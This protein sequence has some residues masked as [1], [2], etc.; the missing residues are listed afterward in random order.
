MNRYGSLAVLLCAAA[1]SSCDY[2]K[3]AVQD[4]TGPVPAAQIKFFNFGVDAP[5]VN[6]YANDAK[7]TAVLSSTGTESTAGVI[8][9]GVGAGGLYSGIA[10]GQYTFSGRIAAA[11]DKDLA[12]SNLMATIEDGK[13][14]S[15]YLSGVYNSTT[16]TV[17]AFIV[18]DPF[19]AAIDWST[20]HVR[21]VNA[22]YNA[23]P[24]TLY[25][26]NQT[27][28]VEVAVGGEAAY[29][30]AGA[31][32]ALPNGLYDLSTRYAGSA[33]NAMIRN[34]VSFVAGRDYTITARG[35]ITVAS[36][37]ATTCASTNRTCLDNTLNR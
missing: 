15:Y 23:N 35:D 25:A 16:K 10:P 8:Y 21:F 32:T 5:G 4:L 19:L 6:F 7:M 1:L 14:Y 3:N 22:I 13:N 36:T 30:A 17:D 27:T 34:S 29:K 33:T 18:E 28:G 37:S 24:M 20:A 31:F 26:R 2:D 11:T 9:G 12:I